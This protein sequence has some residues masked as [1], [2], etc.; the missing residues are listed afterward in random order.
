MIELCGII[1]EDDG[2][3]NLLKKKIS[4]ITTNFGFSLS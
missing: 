1:E 4:N 3:S 2:F